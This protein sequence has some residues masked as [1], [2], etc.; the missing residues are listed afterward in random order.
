MTPSRKP[1][2]SSWVVIERS[3]G[4]QDKGIHPFLFQTLRQGRRRLGQHRRARVGPS[5]KAAVV[6]RRNIADH[7]FSGQLAQTFQ[8]WRALFNARPGVPLL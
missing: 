4:D 3:G 5:H 8:V 2:L 1:C 6:V 7:P